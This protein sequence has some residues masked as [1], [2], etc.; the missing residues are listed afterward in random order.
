MGVRDSYAANI[1]SFGLFSVTRELEMI[2]GIKFIDGVSMFKQ[3]LLAVAV[4]SVGSAY[5]IDNGSFET[6]NVSAGGY[7]YAGNVIA[8]P[9]VFT[10]G[11]GISA[12]SGSW[13]A[14]TALDGTSYAFLQ[15]I[16]SISQ[17]FIG[18][19][20]D[21][22][23]SFALAQ[24]TNAGAVGT[25]KIEV[26]F[27]G[28]K[29]SAQANGQIRPSVFGD[30]DAYGGWTAY[31]FNLGALAAGTHTLSFAG[32]YATGDNTVFLDKVAVTA[33]PEPESYALLLA[34]LGL[35]GAVARR[36]QQK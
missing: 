21:Y 29:L 3:L 23:V 8:D 9:W 15:N 6:S 34:G 32:L 31:S 14:A 24:R 11:A 20:G 10:G 2:R 26:L 16:S 27:D 35:L 5:A 17:S 12:N 18:S 33:V 7:L 19:A 1:S 25:Q 22:T 36:R 4:M 28:Q 13:G 30:D